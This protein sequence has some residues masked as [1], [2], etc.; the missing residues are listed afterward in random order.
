MKNAL[1]WCGG[2]ALVF[3]I[4]LGLA[5]GVPALRLQLMRLYGTE[6]ESVRTDIYRENKS[7][8]EGTV[9]DLREMQVEYTKASDEHKQALA[10]LILHRANELDWERLPVD[11]R[12]FLYELK[13]E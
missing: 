1:K 4:L 11:I 3:G 10:G 13:G 6:T 5:F 8:V 7:Y 12:G 2:L 9:R